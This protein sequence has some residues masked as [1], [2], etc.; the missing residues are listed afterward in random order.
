MIGL[1]DCREFDVEVP[2]LHPDVEGLF[3]GF[4]V[5]WWCCP[6]GL[7]DLVGL[8]I[9]FVTIST[10]CCCSPLATRR[11]TWACTT[12]AEAVAMMSA[13]L[14]PIAV[15]CAASA[16]LTATVAVWRAAWAVAMRVDAACRLLT[17]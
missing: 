7:N 10:A 8:V 9:M 1:V 11:A 15:E 14:V 3:F 12:W 17:A 5:K 13:F 6:T 2:T 16:T 4:D